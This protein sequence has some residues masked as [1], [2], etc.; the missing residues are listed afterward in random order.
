MQLILL[1]LEDNEGRSF[2]E[3]VPR[4]VQQERCDREKDLGQ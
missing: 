4:S 3:A 1:L 2:L